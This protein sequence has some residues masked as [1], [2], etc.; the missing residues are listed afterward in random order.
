MDVCA[1]HTYAGGTPEILPFYFNLS[2]DNFSPTHELDY[3]L[4]IFPVFSISF[5][6]EVQGIPIYS[7]FPLAFAESYRLI[8]LTSKEVFVVFSVRSE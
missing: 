5:S 8:N 6:P 4:L 2:P 7:L 1:P 3:T